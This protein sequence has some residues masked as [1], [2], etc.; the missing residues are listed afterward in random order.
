MA[1]PDDQID[2][3]PRPADETEPSSVLA[4]QLMGTLPCIGCGYE[5]HGLSVLG[6][7]PE[8]GLDVGDTIRMLV[9]PYAE[10][11]HELTNPRRTA[12]L[13][14]GWS[15]AAAVAAGLCWLM[16]GLD[17][18]GDIT[19]SGIRL[20][21]AAIVTTGAILVS[22]ICS[23]GLVRPHAGVRRRGV[24]LAAF[25]TSMYIPLTI[26]FWWV[27]GV[28]D[29]GTQKPYSGVGEISVSRILLRLAEAVLISVIILGLRPH[30][31]M[32]AKRSL[33]LRTGQIDRQTMR[34][35]V[36]AAGV[37]AAG[38]IL[39]LVSLPL[40][41]TASE[42]LNLAGIVGVIMGSA[43]FTLGLVSVVIDTCRISR[44][45]LTSPVT[46]ESLTTAPSDQSQRH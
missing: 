36:A 6:R 46:L 20:Q 24:Y 43:L 40:K 12:V 11:F 37:G 18:F 21:R 26:V 5:L 2:N 4:S 44:A 38:D 35:M 1:E 16:R 34:A 9:D 15:L 13:L 17:I 33:A 28:I 19:G 7:C 14:M 29:H 32:L 45:L 8:C 22:F 27:H 23:L 41:G 42:I 30:A 31:R 10:T 39:R 3:Q 25:A